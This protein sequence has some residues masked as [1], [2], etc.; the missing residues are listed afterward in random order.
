MYNLDNLALE[1]FVDIRNDQPPKDRLHYFD[2]VLESSEDTRGTL[3]QKL[4]VD[5][6]SKSNIDFGKIPDSK[7]DLTKYE[8]YNEI[9]ES[10][11]ALNKLV[12]SAKSD[13][14]AML[15]NLFDITATQ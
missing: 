15:N 12:D 3:I 1:A 10:I 11:G 5:I 8:Y 13:E 9:S 2:V 6:I 4:Y 14:L 7:G